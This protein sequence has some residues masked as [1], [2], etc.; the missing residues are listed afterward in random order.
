MSKRIIEILFNSPKVVNLSKTP[1]IEVQP[2]VFSP[3]YINLKSLLSV[4]KNR[5]VVVRS[6]VKLPLGDIDNI[7][8]IESGGS[9]FASAVADSLNK[10]LILF[11]KN[12]KKYNIKNRF[13][14]ELP[15]KGSRILVV[16]DV[17]SSGN[18]LAEAVTNLKENG[19][20]VEVAVIFSYCWEKEIEKNLKTKIHVLSTARE[21]IEVGALNRKL[22]KG[23][24]NHIEGY[25][26]NEELRVY[27]KQK[28]D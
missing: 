13:A 22:K 10:G 3:V 1:N 28:H 9:Y 4:P 12:E 7:C 14:G 11:R 24:I 6:L 25:I 16:D 26:K 23:N 21:L 27:K 2:G 15:K 18:T 20:K 8:G 19:Y 17:I 5:K